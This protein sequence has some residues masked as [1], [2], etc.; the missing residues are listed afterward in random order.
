MRTYDNRIKYFELLMKYDDIHN[1]KKYELPEGF[2]YEFY[3]PGDEEEWVM[4]HI[5]SGEFTS[6]EKGLKHF[7]DFYDSFIEELPNRCVFIVDDKTGEK[8]GT[9]TISLLKDKEEGY[10]AAVDWVAIKKRYQGRNLSKPLISKFMEIANNVG[11]DKLILHTQTT[12]WLAAK[13]YLD[14]GFEILNVD[15]K[16]GWSILKTLVNHSKL[17][18]YDILSYDEILD[19]RNIEIERQLTEMYGTE[20]FNYSVHYKNGQH[21][22]Y[23]YIDGIVNEYEY[24]IEDG[25]IRLEEV[26][27]KRYNR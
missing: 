12:S 27:N 5:Q 16:M 3:K 13:L 15:E 8:V 20:D 22:V 9:A 1:Y 19:S 17:K 11:H 10:D 2:H 7:H 24:F 25:K 21:N 23:I 26:V 6:I 4:I 18:K 14:Y